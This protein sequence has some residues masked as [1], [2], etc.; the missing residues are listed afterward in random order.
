MFIRTELNPPVSSWVDFTSS[1]KQTILH[2]WQWVTRP[3]VFLSLFLLLFGLSRVPAIRCNSELDPDESLWIGGSPNE[4]DLVPWRSVD[5]TTSGPLNSLPFFLLRK[6]FGPLSYST[7]HAA[8][9]LLLALSVIVLWR[10]LLHLYTA[11]IAGLGAWTRWALPDFWPGGELG[12]VLFGSDPYV[13]LF[14]GTVVPGKRLRKQGRPSLWW[15]LAALLAGSCPWAKLQAA[16]MSLCFF[17]GLC[18]MTL[19]PPRLPIYGLVWA[20]PHGARDSRLHGHNVHFPGDRHLPAG[21]WQDF[22][23]SLHRTEPESY[24]DRGGFGALD[25]PGAST[26][27]ANDSW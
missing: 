21:V 3:V 15:S 25:A 19:W 9:F 20:F 18:W 5:T 1:M 11:K 26:V 27:A 7:V 23:I 12:A 6:V 17:A 24:S 2:L 8:C 13:F 14:A 10:A 22:W 4:H 16:P